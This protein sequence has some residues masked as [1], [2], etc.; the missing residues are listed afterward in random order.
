VREGDND[1]GKALGLEEGGKK[2]SWETG[3]RQIVEAGELECRV[4]DVPF[5]FP[6]N[7]VES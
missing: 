3:M 2:E 1:G 4:A 7:D 5:W 6:F